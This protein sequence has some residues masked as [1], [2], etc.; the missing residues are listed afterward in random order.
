MV[1]LFL[2]IFLCSVG[3][4]ISFKYELSTLP[5]TRTGLQAKLQQKLFFNFCIMEYLKMR[6]K[7]FACKYQNLVIKLLEDGDE[8]YGLF[9]PVFDYIKSW[10]DIL[11]IWFEWAWFDIGHYSSIFYPKYKFPACFWSWKV[12]NLLNQDFY[13][14]HFGRCK[15]FLFLCT[16]FKNEQKWIV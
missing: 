7:V 11:S 10:P 4:R 15:S 3:S 5:L 13:F 9:K 14:V 6:I 12:L 1:T 16:G 2:V 8:L